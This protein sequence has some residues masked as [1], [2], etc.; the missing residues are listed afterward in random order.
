MLQK[1]PSSHYFSLFSLLSLIFLVG[2]CHTNSHLLEPNVC[3]ETTP[4]LL[5]SLPR[6]FKPLSPEEVKTDWG[7]ELMIAHTFVREV[8]LYRAI[9]AFKRALILAPY[10]LMDRRLQMEYGILYC[11]YLGEK[12]S[13]VIQTFE[14]SQLTAVGGSFPPF[15]DLIVILYDS[16]QEVG[17]S[18]KAERVYTLLEQVDEGKANK[19]R[20]SDMILE[21]DLEAAEQEIGCYPDDELSNFLGEYRA[22]S[23]SVRKAQILNACLPGAG[24]YYAG[25]KKAAFTSFVINA[26]FTAATYRCFETGNIAAGIILASLETGW[27]LGGINGAGLAVKEYNQS[28]FDAKARDFLVKQGLFPVLMLE[29]TF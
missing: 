18:A 9:T 7:K 20:L 24:Y 13:E 23:K 25:L 6:A 19:L 8:D 12:Y 14:T 16:Y 5:E 11:Y 3:Y 28:I 29:K 15:K 2:C 26:V 21:G 10:D 1:K 22:E 17:Q 27:Y 4:L